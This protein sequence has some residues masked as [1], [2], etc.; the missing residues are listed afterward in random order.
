MTLKWPSE[1][2]KNDD[3]VAHRTGRYRQGIK[4]LLVLNKNMAKIKSVN[5]EFDPLRPLAAPQQI[6]EI[7]T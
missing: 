7:L 2:P 6:F 1:G 4:M 3:S 5:F